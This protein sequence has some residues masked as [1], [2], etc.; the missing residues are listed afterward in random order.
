MVLLLRWAVEK[1][2]RSLYS[3]EGHLTTAGSSLL[4]RSRT[5]KAMTSPPGSM[6]T[7]RSMSP[8]MSSSL[9]ARSSCRVCL[10]NRS[11]AL[12][13]RPDVGL[14][15]LAGV[16][17]GR[18][19]PLGAFD[20]DGA[21]NVV[22]V[23]H[24]A[25]DS[26]SDLGAR[27]VHLQLLAHLLQPGVVEAHVVRRG[28]EHRQHAEEPYD[29]HA[30]LPP[31]AVERDVGLEGGAD[32]VQQRQVLAPPLPHPGDGPAGREQ[33]TEL[34]DGSLDPIPVPDERAVGRHD[35]LAILDQGVNRVAHPLWSP[36]RM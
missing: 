10:M 8:G 33:A 15:V 36:V 17:V 34:P 4:S 2:A 26:F 6:Q 24:P 28:G 25:E 3:A 9:S 16:D 23:K 11:S 7:R 1:P 29:R 30:L 14:V 5:P 18:R 35:V 21:S 20:V 27:R 19:H 32:V 22:A 12:V 31:L 13:R